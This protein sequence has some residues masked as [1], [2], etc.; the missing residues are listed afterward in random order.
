MTP[1][2]RIAELEKALAEVQQAQER[3][4]KQANN[5]MGAFCPSHGREAGN[6]TYT[7]TMCPRCELADIKAERDTL[8]ELL[9]DAMPWLLS[10]GK[11]CKEVRARISAVL[12]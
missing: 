4:T 7:Y 5:A 8:R 11:E 9:R 6:G 3:M 1:V 12:R 2:E 10:S